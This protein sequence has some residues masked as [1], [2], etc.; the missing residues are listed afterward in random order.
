MTDAD[1]TEMRDPQ[2]PYLAPDCVEIKPQGKAPTKMV[3]ELDPDVRCD[4][5]NTTSQE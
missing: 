1:P 5:G 3:V 4:G 2:N